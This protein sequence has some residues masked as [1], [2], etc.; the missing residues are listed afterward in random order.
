MSEET[1]TIAIGKAKLD[2]F[3]KRT[4][5]KLEDKKNNEYRILP[6][7]GAN[8]A[9]GIW[10]VGHAVHWGYKNSDGKMHPFLCAER[11]K[12]ISKQKVVEVECPICTLLEKAKNWRDSK[13]KELKDKGVGDEKRKEALK[14]VND[15][16]RRFNRGFRVYVNAIDRAGTIGRLDFSSRHH[17]LLI[18]KLKEFEAKGVDCL[19][20]DQGHYFN[21]KYDGKDGH[22]VSVVLE[23]AGNGSMVFKKAPLTPSIVSR[24]K[25]ET[26][27]L[28]D[29]FRRISVEDVKRLA[30]NQKSPDLPQLVDAIF[31]SE[32]SE[33]GS[34]VDEYDDFTDSES[35]PPATARVPEAPSEFGPPL[36]AAAPKQQLVQAAPATAP[37]DIKDMSDDQFKDLFK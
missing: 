10:A 4:N 29:L 28:T 35:G 19:A 8:A 13:D 24:L 31:A 1:E 15:Y 21:F 2:G 17:K 20:P 33:I 22:E 32:R 36:Q 34:A 18:A 7:L 30:D 6:P 26:V 3:Q 12:W 5:F 37:A 23:D 25:S 14:S 16:L 9:K 11:V 27:D